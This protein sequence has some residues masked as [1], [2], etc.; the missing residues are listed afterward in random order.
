[1]SQK[2]VQL[3]NV[4][5][6][7]NKDGTLSLISKDKRLR[8]KPFSLQ[9][10]NNSPSTQTLYN[11]LQSE[12]LYERPSSQIPTASTIRLQNIS[13]SSPVVLG[14]TEHGEMY[15]R[16]DNILLTGYAGAGKTAL[17]KNI[18]QQ[19]TRKGKSS[20]VLTRAE[21]EVLHWNAINTDRKRE[22]QLLVSATTSVEEFFTKL[23]ESWSK[24]TVQDNPEDAAVLVVVDEVEVFEHGEC[25]KLLET[26]ARLGRTYG[27]RL[28]LSTQQPT[29]VRVSP[30]MRE[31]L[32]TRVVLGASN[33]TLQFMTLGEQHGYPYHLFSPGV[34]VIQ[35][36]NEPPMLF[37]AVGIR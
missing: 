2:F 16:G 24:A 34:G 20:I 6:Y 26:I 7:P 10:S 37:H 3:D 13:E 36:R 17:L 1:M 4:R 19:H 23:T 30:M 14:T 29:S 22:E 33:P 9:L 11:L 12:G 21:E 32:L 8:G 18:V 27:F 5:I 31:N 28:V 25:M 35:V 15:L